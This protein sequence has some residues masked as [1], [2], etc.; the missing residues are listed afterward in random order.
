MPFGLI[1]L[2]LHGCADAGGD[3]APPA[4]P[5]WSLAGCVVASE[6]T[7]SVDGGYATTSQCSGTLVGDAWEYEAWQLLT[8]DCLGDDGRTHAEAAA[9]TPEGC[10]TAYSSEWAYPS[11][12]RSSL[13]RAASCDEH[14]NFLEQE[15][16]TTYVPVEGARDTSVTLARYEN[17]YDRDG[18]LI[19][20]VV[21][22]VPLTE[23]T[24]TQWFHDDT[25]RVERWEKERLIG[26]DTFA[27]T[28]FYDYDGALLVAVREEWAWEGLE[29]SDTT[30]YAY[31]DAGRRVSETVDDGADGVI[32]VVTDYGWLA[33]SPW[34]A[35]V[36]T[37][38]A[39][40]WRERD[41]RTAYTYRCP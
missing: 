30:T 16:T 34:V 22:D 7:T 28:G 5:D 4:E 41:E 29:S 38:V 14:G 1:F 8:W 21:E 11:G 32:D 19:L 23:R 27:G 12:Y 18:Q 2:A 37:E 15:E 26:A 17:S 20:Q 25:G 39:S 31:D 36:E 10:E 33:D 6:A 35:T 13:T 24:T 9:W 40:V 3:S